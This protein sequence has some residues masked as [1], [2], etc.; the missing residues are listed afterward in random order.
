MTISYLINI[1][2]SYWYLNYYEMMKI[3]YLIDIIIIITTQII[4]TMIK[5][6]K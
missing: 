3:L 1:E 4:S 2:S 6:S 5:K